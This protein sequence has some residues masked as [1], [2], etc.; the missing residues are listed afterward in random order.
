MGDPRCSIF[1]MERWLK[2]LSEGYFSTDPH[3]TPGSFPSKEKTEFY[4]CLA[5]GGGVERV[6]IF[7]LDPHHATPGSFHHL[8]PGLVSRYSMKSHWIFQ[9]MIVRGKWKIG[10][11]PDANFVKPNQIWFDLIEHIRIFLIVLLCCI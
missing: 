2:G 10:R 7:F 9:E 4:L 5:E 8:E 11:L 1:Y 6:D 3:A